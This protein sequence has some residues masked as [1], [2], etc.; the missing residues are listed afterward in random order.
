MKFGLKDDVINKFCDIFNKYPTVEKV[1]IYGSRAKGNYKR[2]SDID[3]TMFGENISDIDRTNIY[4]DIDDLLTPY[5]ID[6]S[7]YHQI[8]N[9]DLQKH[10]NRIGKVFYQ[11]EET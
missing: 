10:I 11:K 5:T 8:D 7:I 2:S 3:L 9:P 1:I 4:F 6:L